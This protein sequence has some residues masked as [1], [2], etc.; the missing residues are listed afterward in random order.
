MNFKTKLDFCVIP[1]PYSRGQRN[2]VF[3]AYSG[4]NKVD[5]RLRG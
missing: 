2:L 4:T 3:V 5:E 1:S